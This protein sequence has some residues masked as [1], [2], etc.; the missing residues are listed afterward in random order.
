MYDIVFALACMDM[1]F[2]MYAMVCM[3]INYFYCLKIIQTMI[4]YIGLWNISNDRV[5]Q[6][7]HFRELNNY[8]ETLLH[9]FEV[10]SS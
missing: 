3:N 8:Q 9:A 5:Q 6:I 4:N 7:G 10:N 1:D 2:C